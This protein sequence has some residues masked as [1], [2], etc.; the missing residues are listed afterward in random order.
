MGAGPHRHA[1]FQVRV[2]LLVILVA[3]RGCDGEKLHAFAIQQHFQ[4]MRLAQALYLFIAVACE[5]D[6]DV[7][8]AVPRERAVLKEA[9]ACAGRQPFD[10]FLLREVRAGAEGI[11]AGPG[12]RCAHRLTADFC[13]GVR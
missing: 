2:H 5:A 1:H 3:L 6:L 13:G 8:L 9:A 10:A 7:I 4:F 11:A 12:L